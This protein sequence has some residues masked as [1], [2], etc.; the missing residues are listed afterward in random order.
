MN[1][2]G[3]NL[4]EL[5]AVTRELERCLAEPGRQPDVRLLEAR[6]LL[7]E[8]LREGVDA[9]SGRWDLAATHDIMELVCELMVTVYH[10]ACDLRQ[11]VGVS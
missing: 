7:V 10:L 4:Q 1:E 3:W 11:I 8:H 9:L 6:A 5:L 2:L